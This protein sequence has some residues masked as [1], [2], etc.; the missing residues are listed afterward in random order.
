MVAEMGEQRLGFGHQAVADL[1]VEDAPERQLG[2]NVHAQT[3][4]GNEGGLGRYP[5]MAAKVVDAPGLQSAE[6]GQ[7]AVHV[8]RRVPG[9]RKNAGV[10]L[11]TQESDPA[12]DRE[13]SARAQELAQ[14]RVDAPLVAAGRR[15]QNHRDRVEVRFKFVPT[16]RPFAQRQDG[17]DRPV[18]RGREMNRHDDGRRHVRCSRV[19][20]ADGGDVL[21]GRIVDGHP[22]A[23]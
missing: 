20:G 21:A 12:V 9:E 13:L 7:P 8:H 11:A 10:V 4:G 17:L 2:L 18:G 15:V 6:V 16:P 5:G 23:E 1:L 14:A 22:N 19:V 3:V